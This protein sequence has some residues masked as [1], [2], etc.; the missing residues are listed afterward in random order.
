MWNGEALSTFGRNTLK[1]GINYFGSMA[2]SPAA[3]AISKGAG[4]GLS[5]IKAVSKKV[6]LPIIAA[7]STYEAMKWLTDGHTA[8]D[9]LSKGKFK[10]V[11]AGS[12]EAKNRIHGKPV[13]KQQTASVPSTPSNSKPVVDNSFS[14]SELKGKDT[15]YDIQKRMGFKE[16]DPNATLDGKFGPQTFAAMKKAGISVTNDNGKL[17]GGFKA[18]TPVTKQAT[19][20]VV[21]A[22]DSTPTRD[23]KSDAAIDMM[24]NEAKANNPRKALASDISKNIVEP[25]IS[26]TIK[27]QEM[28]KKSF[29]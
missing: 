15:V 29:T 20:N 26:K 9:V 27:L 23:V 2:N 6:S 19:T 21:T 1:S 24:I 22:V 13:L 4:E 5:A 16:N 18:S 3:G 28:Q 10:P 7:T 14:L 8:N 11:F 17:F 12:D 25:S